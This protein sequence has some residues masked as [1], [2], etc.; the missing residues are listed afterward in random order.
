MCCMCNVLIQ[1]GW[2]QT[3]PP[4]CI[5]YDIQPI[6]M[7]PPETSMRHYGSSTQQPNVNRFHRWFQFAQFTPFVVVTNSEQI[8]FMQYQQRWKLTSFKHTEKKI[9]AFTNFFSEYHIGDMIKKIYHEKKIKL[10]LSWISIFT[11]T[12]HPVPLPS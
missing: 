12:K 5:T 3:R 8:L 10:K 2:R 9:H 6:H 7:G 11:I 4:A 1:R